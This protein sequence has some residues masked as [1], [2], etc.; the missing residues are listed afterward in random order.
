MSPSFAETNP[1][2]NHIGFMDASTL[3]ADSNGQINHEMLYANNSVALIPYLILPLSP[4]IKRVKIE[5]SDLKNLN[6]ESLLN[7]CLSER[8]CKSMIKSAKLSKKKKK[9]II[10]QLDETRELSKES[11]EDE[12]HR[13]S[14]ESSS[15]DSETEIEEAKKEKKINNKRRE[16]KARLNESKTKKC[17]A[18]ADANENGPKPNNVLADGKSIDEPGEA[19]AREQ[20]SH[21]IEFLLAIIGF[22]VDLGNVWRCNFFFFFYFLC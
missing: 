3:N 15:E 4:N 8:Q 20:W 2:A 12:N 22:S 9:K 14:S 19:V 21:K 16:K 18:V 5:H 17:L 6:S 1:A 11:F 13:E 10:D 7:S